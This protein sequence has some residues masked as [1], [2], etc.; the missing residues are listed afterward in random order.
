MFCQISSVSQPYRLSFIS[1]HIL[2]IF[3]KNYQMLI[4]Y[5]FFKF[6]VLLNISQYVIYIDMR[7]NSNNTRNHRGQ[8]LFKILKEFIRK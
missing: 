4:R 5:D 6:Q 7:T 8:L 2:T 3:A 1:N